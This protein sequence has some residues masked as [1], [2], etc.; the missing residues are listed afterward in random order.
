M[1]G[2]DREPE[3]EPVLLLVEVRSVA[4]STTT[5]ARVQTFLPD[6][7]DAVT[8]STEYGPSSKTNT[9]NIQSY[10]FQHGTER[11]PRAFNCFVL[12]FPTA[13]PT[14]QMMSNGMPSAFAKF[15]EALNKMMVM[16]TEGVGVWCS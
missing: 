9:T 11:T 7:N 4:A 13:G 1:A 10:S 14:K 8:G 5:C 16:W 12:P 2:N 3:D 6:H 15:G